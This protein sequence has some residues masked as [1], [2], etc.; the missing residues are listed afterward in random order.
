MD[1]VRLSPTLIVIMLQAP[2]NTPVTEDVFSIL[3]EKHRIPVPMLPGKSLLAMQFLYRV[4]HCHLC[5]NL[6]AHHIVMHI[7]INFSYIFEC[8]GISGFFFTKQG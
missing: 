5:Y 2:L 8:F 7:L 4:R 6:D 1:V 3:M